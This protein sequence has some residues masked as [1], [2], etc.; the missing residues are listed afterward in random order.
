M[1]D[2]GMM[3]RKNDKGYRYGWELDASN[4]LRTRGRIE[5]ALLDNLILF[6][7]DKKS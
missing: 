7:P 5:D 3:K 1:V 6:P 4:N 2:N